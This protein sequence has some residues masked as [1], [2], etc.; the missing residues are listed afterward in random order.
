MKRFDPTLFPPLPAQLSAVPQHGVP[1]RRKW[2]HWWAG[3]TIASPTPEVAVPASQ[4][5]KSV[6]RLM[7]DV[8]ALNAYYVQETDYTR[9]WVRQLLGLTPTTPVIL[10]SSGTSAIMTATRMFAHIGRHPSYGGIAAGIGKIT[11]FFTVTTSEEGS[12]VTYALKGKDPNEVKNVMFFPN[13]SLFFEAAP[14]LGFPQGVSVE[15]KAV[16]LQKH[17]NAAVVEEIG[18]AVE[19]LSQGGLSCGCILLPTVSKS[20]RIL[21]VKEV[22]ALVKDL[23]SRGHNLFFVVDDVQ[24]MARQ[25]AVVHTDPL[26]YCDAYLFSASKALGGLLIASAVAMRE[27]LVH[28]FVEKTQGKDFPRQKAFAHFQF[29]TRFEAELPEWIVKDSAVSI[30]ELVAMNAAMMY[31]YHRGKG[32]T[33][34][35]RRL[36]QLALVEAQRAEI[37]KAISAVPGVSV[38]T[39]T[40][41]RP[42]VPSIISFE[43][44][45]QGATPM[46]VKQALQAGDTI[47]TPTAP[48]GSF[49]RL[50]IPEYR[51]VPP[52][53]VLADKLARV[54]DSLSAK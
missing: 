50:D 30:P 24:G 9:Y 33:F 18:K 31:F 26:S 45:R 44:D 6:K 32:D 25:D 47:I 52:A 23:R 41:S 7:E 4:S 51:S 39:A 15:Q 11:R 40:P 10:E 14:V 48:V 27:E 13:T 53:D 20:G 12:L 22:A 17:D 42:L 29:E 1:W 54:I 34:S 5:V 2:K 21:P 37:V 19:E 8:D 28:A 36:A 43:I 49:L 16:N 35:Q 3:A 46:K 38:L